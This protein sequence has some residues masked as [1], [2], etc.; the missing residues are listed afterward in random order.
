[1][2]ICCYLQNYNRG[3]VDFG[4]IGT[5]RNRVDDVGDGF[6]VPNGYAIRYW[7][8]RETRPLQIG[9][10]VTEK[11]LSFFTPNGFPV[12][13]KGKAVLFV[14]SLFL[15]GQ[16]YP[17]VPLGPS[18][19]ASVLDDGFAVTVAPVGG[20]GIDKADPGKQGI[21]QD[22]VLPGECAEGYQLVPVRQEKQLCVQGF[23]LK[24][25]V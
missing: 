10:Y 16:V 21:V 11:Y 7:A 1:M 3:F 13:P 14:Q 8:G 12:L 19:G 24:Q 22:L 2:G 5:V 18:L 4:N 25:M 20:E 9:A 23:G 6:P 15:A 17:A